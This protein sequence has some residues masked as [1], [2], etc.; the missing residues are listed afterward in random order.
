MKKIS[1]IAMLVIASVAVA[2][3]FT[4][5]AKRAYTTVDL[6]PSSLTDGVPGEEKGY[7]LRAVY[8]TIV[9]P[10]DAGVA[11]EDIYSAVFRAWVTGAGGK[12][13]DG[14]V[15]YSWKRFPQLDMEFTSDA[16]TAVGGGYNQ[17]NEGLTMT[18]VISDL[19]P[20]SRLM[21]SVHN[22]A[23]VDGGSPITDLWVEGVYRLDSISR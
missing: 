2:T 1:L 22:M 7:T 18:R 11:S 13:P 9:Q 3:P 16:G 10:Y 20:A 19:P 8:L 17:T 23:V 5:F 4:K 21:Y 14:G 15:G 6:Q 12:F